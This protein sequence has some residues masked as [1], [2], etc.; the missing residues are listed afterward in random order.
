MMG[1]RGQAYTLEGVVGAIL[2]ATAVIFGLQAVDVSPWTQGTSDEKVD[3][4]RTQA[5]DLLSI[6]GE[7]GMLERAVTCYVGGEP[8]P[9]IG[10]RSPAAS[11]TALG[12]MLNRTFHEYGF[13]Y[14]LYF[15]Y[16]NGTTSETIH[17]YPDEPRPAGDGA[18]TVTRRVTVLNS[19]AAS[20][21]GDC[22]TRGRTLE[23]AADDIDL[24]QI[25]DSEVFHLVEV[26]L[27]VW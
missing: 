11:A 19:T 27:V 7:E 2:I 21:D 25:S 17:V 15:T 8:A 23:E 5:Q 16:A 24:P 3:S 4:L 9:T 18:V 12:P 14:N 6:A 22:S 26:R 20:T 13:R 10:E 1:D